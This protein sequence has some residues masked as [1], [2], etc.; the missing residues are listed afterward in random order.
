MHKL[1]VEFIG[2]LFFVLTIGLNVLNPGENASGLAPLAI[3]S[4]LMVM[5]YSG[6]HISGGHFNPAVTLGVMIRGKIRPTEV[7]GYMVA[8]VLGSVAASFVAVYFKGEAGGGGADTFDAGRV[9]LAELLFTFLL[10]FTV[11]NVATAKGTAGNSFYGLAIGFAVLVGAFSAGDI[12]G[13][14]FNPAIAVGACVMK[15]SAWTTL[16][17]YLAAQFLAGT[18]AGYLFKAVHPGES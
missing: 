1:I 15:L 4:V 5:V 13:A 9:I 18:C 3:G 12:S 6:G 8:Q 10:V 7:P 16:W 11:L 14:A 2:T 17:A